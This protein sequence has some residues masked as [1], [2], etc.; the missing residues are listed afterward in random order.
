LKKITDA[1]IW[2]T[3]ISLSYLENYC[4]AHETTW[5]TN[6]E[7][8]RK[9]LKEKL[10]DEKLVNEILKVTKKIV[11]QRSTTIVVRKQI[12]KEKRLALTQIQSKTTVNTVR[13]CLSTQK[14]DGSIELN[15]TISRDVDVSKESLTTSLH[16]YAV[17]DKVKKVTDNTVISTALAISY[18][19]NTASAHEKHW[20]TQYENARNYL[21]K[22]VNDKQLEEEILKSCNKMV[23]QKTTSKVIR[24]DKAKKKQETLA[25]LNNKT[26]GSTVS[27]IVSTQGKDGSFG[28]SR[29]LSKNLGVSSSESLVTSIKSFAVSDKL[30]EL[31]NV[32]LFETAIT[33]C[34]LQNA[35][36]SQGQNLSDQYKKAREYLQKEINNKELEEEL[37]KTCKKYVIQKTVTVIVRK[38]R[39]KEK[40]IALTIA[41]SKT[42][43][44]TTKKV[45]SAQKQDGS[46]ELN[47]EVSRE[48]DVS[49]P[50]TLSNTCK[51]FSTNERLKTIED[52][53]IWTTA[54][55]RKKIQILIIK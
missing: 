13:D 18:L 15:E 40:R 20:K 35:T 3:A 26:S 31:K 51:V 29:D 11:I 37:L 21:H 25:Y 10:K 6:S 55:T 44:E 28:L 22:K 54:I 9:F 34:Y 50:D 53:S 49:S 38:Q 41:Q 30:K 14:N 48:L 36:A 27:S 1:D 47:E 4:G 5:K 24:K 2:K 43:V 16:S 17:S 8:A 32:K 42:T 12:K 7:K 45:V 46:F 39:L 23:V 33:I 52:N 19:I